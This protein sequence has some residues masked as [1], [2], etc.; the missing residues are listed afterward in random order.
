MEGLHYWTVTHQ[1][2]IYTSVEMNSTVFEYLMVTY[3]CNVMAG[4]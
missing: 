1:V 2:D 3:Y 4:I